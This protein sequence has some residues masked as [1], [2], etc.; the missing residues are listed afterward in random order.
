MAVGRD[1]VGADGL[2]NAERYAKRQADKK[3]RQAAFRAQQDAKKTAAA[4]SVSSP[5][6]MFG[7]LLGTVKQATTPAPTATLG[8]GHQQAPAPIK[9]PP[10]PAPDPEP[11][12]DGTY[13][14]ILHQETGDNAVSL[15]GFTG[16]DKTT[17]SWSPTQ[18]TESDLQGIY[19][20]STNLQNVFGSF[21]RYLSYIKESSEM[22]ESQDWFS[23]EGIDQTTKAQ[24]LQE[25]DD[26]AFG[27]GQQAPV[28]DT[29]QSDANARQGA[30]AS[31][32]NS[33]ENQALMNKY[34][35][36]TEEFT[37]E[38]GDRFRWTGTGFAR[39]YKMNRTDFG[40]YVKAIGAAALMT[41]APQLAAAL[42]NVGMAPIAAQALAN[43]T[44]S[45]ASQAATTG[46]V[47][48]NT[49]IQDTIEG[50]AN[51]DFGSVEGMSPYD[52]ANTIR[53]A[54]N[55]VSDGNYD[56]SDNEWST[57]DTS[58]AGSG[59]E[60]DD[61][62][63]FVFTGGEVSIE[64]PSYEIIA[65]TVASDYT[66]EEVM[67]AQDIDS[68][69]Y[70]DYINRMNEL[71]E[72]GINGQEALEVLLEE[73][74]ISQEDY[75]ATVAEVEQILAENESQAA[76]EN[77]ELV[78][79]TGDSELV[80][81]GVWEPAGTNRVRQADGTYK[82]VYV[83]KNK[84]TGEIWEI[85]EEELGTYGG[86]VVDPSAYEN[87]TFDPDQEFDEFE[88]RIWDLGIE[89]GFSVEE[90]LQDIQDYRDQQVEEIEEEVEEE[91]EEEGEDDFTF[92]GST[93]KDTTEETVEEVVEDILTNTTDEGEDDFTF[94]GSTTKDTTEEVVEEVVEET[95]EDPEAEQKDKEAAETA[96]DIA[97][98]LLKDS[99]ADD[100]EGGLTF[101]GAATKDDGGN[102]GE[103]VEEVVEEPGDNG[104]ETELEIA[105]DPTKDGGDDNGEEPGDVG[106]TFGGGSDTKD[107]GD[108]GGETEVEIATDPTKDGKDATG[109][110]DT[111]G[112]K[113]ATG[114]S[115][116]EG[117]D[118][119]GSSDTEGPGEEPGDEG[120]TFGGGST[121]KDT[122]D[123]T[124]SSDTEGKDGTGDS[125]TEGKDGTGSSDSEGKD[126]TGDSDT[127][128]KDG[129]GDSDTEGPGEEE[130]MSLFSLTKDAGA[131]VGGGGGSFKP[132]M[133]GISYEAPTAQS[134]IQSPNVD[135][136][137]QLNK[138][139][140]KGM[141]V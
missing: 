94:G 111:E 51:G 33:A 47:D 20:D 21:D 4:P 22:I 58:P 31:W 138:I 35:I 26:L 128:G 120:L 112:G 87:S 14:M 54:I 95:V 99:T 56:Y 48:L 102:G 114:T 104:G 75:D 135:Y 97:E 80:K 116:T 122:K 41:A 109:T 53:D 39:T 69:A 3:A 61:D 42:V 124:G 12:E 7:S 77:R 13:T 36:P 68:S 90:I 28:N 24:E 96:K 79:Y 98:Q 92:G 37:N 123:G 23:Q 46:D 29:Q 106:F 101:G 119:T 1:V 132:F 30:Y 59:L 34:G 66:T 71:S 67:Q 15:F 139:I 108:G 88:Q 127:E 121:T 70:S 25:E 107:T 141:L 126:G 19:S 9:T 57:T 32:M 16:E 17:L 73:G 125:D 2:T 18:V 78:V 134:I 130:A 8:F 27:P 81:D 117:K 6:S 65:E 82:N 105:L 49:V 136:M 5:S 137:A 43:A 89:G 115:D 110:S 76:S 11:E 113:D 84:D 131:S 74:I 129:T 72:Q 83:Y 62:G 118:G 63:N 10:P 91:V 140:N 133:A 52:I 45:L 40:D 64:A 44:L 38:K 86:T 50:V 55:D 103:V 93:T 85:P 100:S 60:T